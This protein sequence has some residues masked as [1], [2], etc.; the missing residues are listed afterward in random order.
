MNFLDHG[1]FEDLSKILPSR[2]K[3]AAVVVGFDYR[4]NYKKLA[5][6]QHYLR[7]YN[8]CSFIATSADSSA[9][10]RHGIYPGS[11]SIVSAVTVATGRNPILLGKPE[12]VFLDCIKSE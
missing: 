12:T 11:G 1:H 5:V 9:P 3:V 6:A 4:F 7:K 10:T 2:D 8:S